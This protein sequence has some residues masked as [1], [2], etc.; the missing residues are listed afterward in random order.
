M[1]NEENIRTGEKTYGIIRKANFL[2]EH[3]RAQYSLIQTRFILY[4]LSLIEPNDKDFKFLQIPVSSLIKIS[5][6]S[7]KL[8]HTL[9]KEAKE[10]LEKP[11]FL[12]TEGGGWIGFNW[13]SSI[14]YIPGK[15]I[16]EVEFSQKLKPYLLDL[17]EFFTIYKLEHVLPMRSAYSPRIYELLKE[18]E[19]IPM[20]SEGGLKFRKFTVDWIIKHFQ[21]DEKPSMME[22]KHIKQFII[23]PA[24]RDINKYSDLYIEKLVE[25]KFARKVVDFTIYFRKKTP[26]EMEEQ[27]KRLWFEENGFEPP[28]RV[29]ENTT[30][31]ETRKI[32]E[33]ETGA[34]FEIKPET[35]SASESP[36]SEAPAKEPPASSETISEPAKEPPATPEPA[37]E[38]LANIVQAPESD[39]DMQE[40]RLNYFYLQVPENHRNSSVRDVLKQFLQESDDY[41]LRNLKY[42]IKKN[43]ENFAGYLYKALENDYAKEEREE[44]L[45]Q[46]EK[47]KLKAEWWRNKIDEAIATMP[48]EEKQEFMHFVEIAIAHKEIED[49][50]EAREKAFRNLVKQE[51]EM[52]G[53]KCPYE[54]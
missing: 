1:D 13:F 38:A 25:H 12:P 26:K 42:T 32:Y 5:H 34:V 40:R 22:Y 43:P 8:Y 29:I 33:P 10:L 21:L 6:S 47:K 20:N 11:F 37:K 4:A 17:K 49:T 35:M 28:A 2:L 39:S 19:N 46:E 9:K 48:P 50:E 31:N 18:Y 3:M 36:S 24:I 45:S 41:I 44:N 23:N 27:E 15:G 53:V 52:E 7:T 51:L 54:D 14:E 16:I 30:A